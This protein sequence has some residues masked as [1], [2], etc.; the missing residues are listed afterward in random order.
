MI[1]PLTINRENTNFEIQT[2]PLQ[3]TFFYSISLTLYS[4][5]SSPH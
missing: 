3:L 4:L 2:S 1:N 5:S